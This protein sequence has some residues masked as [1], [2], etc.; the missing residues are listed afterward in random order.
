[1]CAE[2]VCYDYCRNQATRDRESCQYCVG[3]LC[4]ADCVFENC[5]EICEDS[6]NVV[7]CQNC[8]KLCPSKKQKHKPTIKPV[9][10]E[11][12]EEFSKNDDQM[13]MVIEKEEKSDEIFDYN[14]NLHSWSRPHL[15]GKD[16]V[17][18]CAIA[19]SEIC[20]KP[21]QACA[22]CIHKTCKGI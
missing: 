7:D 3:N 12:Y 16:L 10:D 20:E 2:S 9:E 5:S 8:A 14:Y 4:D 17:P 13:S 21:V 6:Q 11:T 18:K 22:L 19:C 1:M 15:R